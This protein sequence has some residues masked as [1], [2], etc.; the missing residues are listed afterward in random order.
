[1]GTA[2]SRIFSDFL[3]GTHTPN[4]DLQKRSGIN[5]KVVHFNATGAILMGYQYWIAYQRAVALNTIVPSHRT[6]ACTRARSF[7]SNTHTQCTGW[8]HVNFSAQGS[9]HLNSPAQGLR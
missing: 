4:G 3:P 9:E 6:Q 1:M 7:S 5:G 8:Q 2:D